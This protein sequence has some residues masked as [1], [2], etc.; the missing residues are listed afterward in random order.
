MKPIA[1]EKSKTED[2]LKESGLDF[3]IIRPGNL[4][5][6]RAT[7]NGALVQDERLTG[8]IYRE[9]LAP[10]IAGCLDDPSTIGEI[11][12]ALDRDFVGVTDY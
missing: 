2:Y 6:N 7:G 4:R 11:Y 8:T 12:A 3:T 1:K 10:L 9:D 5:S